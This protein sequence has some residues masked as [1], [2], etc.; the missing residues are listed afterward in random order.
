M[1]RERQTVNANARN[2]R[3][4]LPAH[5]TPV[6]WTLLAL[7]IAGLLLASAGCASPTNP[8]GTIAGSEPQPTDEQVIEAY[9]K[10]P[11]SFVPNQGQVADEQ[12]RYHAQGAGFGFSFT[13]T[14]AMFSFVGGDALDSG[15]TADATEKEPAAARGFALALD[16]LEANP[17]AEIE[18]REEL[19]GKVN[20]LRGSDPAEHRP[21]RQRL[22][23]GRDPLRR[24]PHHARGLRRHIPRRR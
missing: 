4:A 5:A 21:V 3:G 1:R 22:R 6:V 24:L 14:G 11:L 7:L 15:E 2:R 19:A 9:G 10:L 17:E 23:D 16:F 8:L 20:Y 13:P 12:V 18:A